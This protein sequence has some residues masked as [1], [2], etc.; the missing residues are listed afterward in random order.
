MTYTNDLG[1]PERGMNTK[2]TP[3]DSGDYDAVVHGIVS[4]GLN[5][6]VYE[7]VQKTPKVFL[8]VI[9]ELPD[10]LRE[11]GTTITT[12]R[13]IKVSNSVDLGNWAK[14]LTALGEKV[15]EQNIK[16]YSSRDKLEDLL[17]KSVVA[18]VDQWESDTGLT[19]S[20]KEFRKLDPRL[21]QPKAVRE[22]FFFNP[23]S[24][25]LKIFKENLTFRTKQEVM[26][27]LNANQFP[28]ELHQAWKEAQADNASKQQDKGRGQSVTT[29][30][31]QQTSY[32]SGEEPPFDV[33]SIG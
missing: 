27:A 1:A 6:D 21:P 20:I 4:L 14:F 32:H 33:E 10:Q 13:K 15:T 8:R 12:S 7:G 2:Y 9:V 22:T 28:A 3:L 23:L 24:P 31:M 26:S 11:D 17:G 30:P 16:S 5:P 25:D 19:A 18:V 29:S